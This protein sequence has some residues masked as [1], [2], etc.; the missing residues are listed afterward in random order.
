MTVVT[1]IWVWLPGRDEPTRAGELVHGHSARFI[2]RPD[3]LNAEGAL[4]LDPVELRLSR[5]SRGAAVLGSDGLPG[6]VRDA[7][8][9]GYGEDRL[10]AIHGDHLDA[11]QLLEL[12]VPDG[13][14][15]IEACHDIE[16][17]LQWRPKGLADLQRLTEDLD[18]YEPSSRALRRLNDD[19][20]TSAGGERPKA[21]LVHEGRL[22]LVKMQARGD[23]PAMPAR[24]FVTMRL[25]EQAGLLVAPVKLH[26]FG[27]HQVLMVQ[28]FDRGGD[29]FKP[30]R[31]LYASAH[32]ALRL[33]LDA[34]KGDP[35]RSYL[36][37]ADRLRIWTR[38]GAD[39]DR[40][41]LG[42]QLV[43]LWQRM[44]F[45]AL[46]GNTDDHARNTGLL[47]DR[48]G[49]GH[50]RMAWGLSPAFDITPNMVG[51]PP[52]IEEGPHLS[53][54]TWTDG[55]SST[56]VARLADAAQRMGLDRSEAI[57]WLMDTAQQVA[58]Q[59]E[60]MLRSVASPAI[61]DAAR[62]ERL[63]DDVRPSFAYAQWLAQLN[64][65]A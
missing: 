3:Y 28:R 55:R 22:W 14:G 5:S 59:W 7:K 38:G 15:A 57:Q 63:V 56:S 29:P 6:V 25:A 9:A 4:A 13:V 58:Q 30:T 12:G 36:G 51:L 45:N 17:K 47:F 19:L 2:Y 37:L 46:V 18:A 50:D 21:T 34:V 62:M 8:P 54:A 41:R 64:W 23:R 1:P 42:G 65:A 49:E 60:P 10:K 35:E 20:D 40:E 33:R 53:L 24:E 26:S 48:V 27:A 16:R 61:E 44:A 52:K 32:T 39:D 31:K 43:E 11:L